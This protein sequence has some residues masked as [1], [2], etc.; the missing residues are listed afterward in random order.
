ML[1]LARLNV[2]VDWEEATS[3]QTRIAQRGTRQT[4]WAPTTATKCK[5]DSMLPTTRVNIVVDC[6]EATSR[7]RN[8][9]HYIKNKATSRWLQHKEEEGH[10]TIAL[11]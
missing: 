10:F 8:K 7:Q 1:P 2:V 11:Y 4:S 5:L 9:N 6:D 3:R